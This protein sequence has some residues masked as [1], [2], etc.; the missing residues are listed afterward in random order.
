MLDHRVVEQAWTLPLSMK[1]RAGQGKWVLREIVKKYVPAELIERPKMGFGVPISSWLRG[2]LRDWAENL[3]DQKRLRDQG[4]LHPD[5]ICRKWKAHVSG[6]ADWQ[7]QLW[8]VLMFQAWIED[9]HAS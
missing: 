4:F 2:S 8:D 5:V 7:N 3:I 9:T 1:V 6:A